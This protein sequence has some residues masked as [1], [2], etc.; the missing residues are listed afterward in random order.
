[1]QTKI[2]LGFGLGLLLTLAACTSPEAGKRIDAFSQAVAL[3]SANTKSAFDAVESNYREAQVARI[4]ANYDDQ[5][6]NPE[7][8]KPFLSTADLEARL[9]VL[10]GLQ[11]YALRLSEIMGDQQMNALDVET[12]R[13][14]RAM[15]AVNEDF[16]KDRFFPKAGRHDREVN[17]FTTAINA[18]GHWL[19]DARRQRGVKQTIA[20]MQEPVSNICQLLVLDIGPAPGAEGVPPA[21]LRVQLSNQYKLILM[22]QD[23]FIR[24]N[25]GAL[26]PIA[27]RNEIRA[28]AA[29]V[30]EQQKA[31]A[32]LQAMQQAVQQLN[33]T[34]A[35][36]A[37]AFS[38][39]PAHLDV[40]TRQLVAD[41]KR[42]S[43][44]YRS[45]E[46]NDK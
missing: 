44:F 14:G 28:L 33:E 30:T 20:R 37:R 4:V 31:D 18:L 45:L 34:H 26:D 27:R 13:L 32:T 5:G 2:V 24:K 17:G 1:M 46:N 15:Q 43:A 8:I 3:T 9:L 38:K 19:I 11:E 12:D 39:K 42:I 25:K 29:L 40:L 10:N 35:Q 21:G 7:L 22:E 23:A 36:L 6:F 16:V 41:G